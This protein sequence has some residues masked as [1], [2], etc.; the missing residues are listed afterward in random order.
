MDVQQMIGSHPD[1]AGR[2]SEPL[3]VCIEECF[4]A[5]QACVSCA[6]ACLAEPERDALVQCIR[7]TLDCAD[8]CSAAGAVA[9]RRAGSNHAILRNIISSASEACRFCG[10]ECEHHAERHQ[11]CRLCAEACYRCDAAC[12]TALQAVH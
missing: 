10:A 3:V 11:H 5:A 2:V 4:A 12:R 6:D 7:L 8:I 1:V 9:S